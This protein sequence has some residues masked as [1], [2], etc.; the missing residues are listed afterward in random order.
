MQPAILLAFIQFG[1]GSAILVGVGYLVINTVIGQILEPK[2]M[3]HDLGLST[4]VVFLSL[5]FW[6]WV[7]GPVGM[8]LSGKF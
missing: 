8:V 2:Y 6:G 1:L 7:L 3:G 5:V 4:L